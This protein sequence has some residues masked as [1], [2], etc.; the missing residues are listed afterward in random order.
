MVRRVSNGMI[1][2][3][4]NAWLK[5]HVTKRIP[6]FP[7]QSVNLWF[8]FLKFPWNSPKLQ[9]PPP[10]KKHHFKLQIPTY[11]SS[12]LVPPNPCTYH[13]RTFLPR[14]MARCTKIWC[15]KLP[16]VTNWSPEGSHNI[17]SIASLCSWMKVSSFGY[18]LNWKK[19]PQQ[20]MQAFLSLSGH[21]YI[22]SF[23][24][25]FWVGRSYFCQML[26]MRPSFANLKYMNTYTPSGLTQTTMI[27]LEKWC[28]QKQ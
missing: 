8:V 16:Q 18:V 28:L 11:T 19:S 13:P 4:H 3:L 17:A 21:L 9:L 6:S 5:K 14:N 1:Q 23:I 10:P 22:Q 27:S 26:F 7:G 24:C 25:F 2:D 20:V 12:S 15:P